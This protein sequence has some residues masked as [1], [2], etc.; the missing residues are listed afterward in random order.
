MPIKL[1]ENSIKYILF[2]R[3]GYLKD[4]Y[5]FNLLTWFGSFNHFYKL[6]VYLKSVLFSS[7]IRNEFNKNMW[8]EYDIIRPYL[9][10]IVKSILDIGC[11]TAGIDVL[12]S[13]HYQNAINIFL[14]DKTCVDKRIYYDFNTNGSFYNSLRISK[15]VLECNGVLSSRIY[16]QEATEKNNILFNQQFDIIISLIS[17]GFH[18]PI[19]TYLTEV[20]EKLN[21]NGVLILDIRKGTCGENEIEQKFGKYTVLLNTPKF[22][23]ILVKK[24]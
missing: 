1:P 12:I 16:L 3:T 15:K 7:K 23:R 21:K 2:Q 24:Q 18:Y 5:V 13:K 10:R 8:L 4:N 20:Y 6:S 22:I 9:P 14:I 11:G 19:N 17:W